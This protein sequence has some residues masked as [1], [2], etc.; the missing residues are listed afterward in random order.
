MKP[1]EFIETT[2]IIELEDIVERHPYLAFLLIAI[3]IEFLGKC[4]MTS[5]QKWHNIPPDKGF[6]KGLS[7]LTNI[8]ERYGTL[9]L[10][11]ELRNGFAHTLSPKSKLALSERK[12]GDVHFGKSS[13]EKPI[14]VVEDFYKDFVKSCHVILSMNFTADDKV[15][16]EFIRIEK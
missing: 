14:L 2:L 12:S 16:Q 13:F 7:L 9:N 4:L 8:D 1:K 5:H 3:G 15:N 6:E 11:D 10:R